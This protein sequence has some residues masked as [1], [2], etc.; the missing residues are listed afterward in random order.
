MLTFQEQNISIFIPSLQQY[1]N[2]CLF[3]AMYM[4][5]IVEFNNIKSRNLKRASVHNLSLTQMHAS[6]E[7]KD[8]LYNLRV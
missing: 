8:L 7:F 4:Q 3:T 6:G 2:N 5:T 1:I